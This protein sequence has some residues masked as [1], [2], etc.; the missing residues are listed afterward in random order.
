MIG[1]KRIYE[2]AD[3]ADGCRVLVDRLW[4]RGMSKAR[5]AVDYWARDAAPSDALRRWYGH[6]PA[7]WD[8]FRDRY[9]TFSW[10]DPRPWFHEAQQLGKR[11]FTK[12]T[13]RD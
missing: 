3:P 13:R 6:D 9:D 12:L 1:I 5:A 8:E 10:D 4:P 2:P 7:R 11:L